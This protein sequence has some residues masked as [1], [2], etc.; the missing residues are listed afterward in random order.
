VA[1]CAT[2]TSQKQRVYKLV[3]S[4]EAAAAAL[5]LFTIVIMPFTLAE[6]QMQGSGSVTTIT[7]M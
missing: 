1:K 7:T 4:K 6:S 5:G 2:K 3:S